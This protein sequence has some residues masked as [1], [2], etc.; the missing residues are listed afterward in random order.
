MHWAG[1]GL[2]ACLD[3]ITGQAKEVTNSERMGTEQ[4][5]LQTDS[6]AI[7]SSHL[8]H[9]LK[10]SIQKKPTHR[11][12]VHA[13]DRPT[14]IGDIDGLHP[15]AHELSHG[16]RMAGITATGRHHFGS[17]GDRTSLKTA[18]QRGTQTLQTLLPVTMEDRL[19]ETNA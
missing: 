6:I 4:I 11:Q 2:I 10:T 12:A 3:R 14:A 15:T 17:N 18:L 13:H 1:I 7:S 19:P 16:Q 8:Q 9:R 5:R